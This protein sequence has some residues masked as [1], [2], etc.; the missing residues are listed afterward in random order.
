VSTRALA[1]PAA[2]TSQRGG[3]PSRPRAENVLVLYKQLAAAIDAGLTVSR[4]L[5]GAMSEMQ[6]QALRAAVEDLARRVNSG[7]SLSSAM[8]Q[9]PRC[10]SSLACNMVRSAERSGALA[11]AL[12][13]V[14]R[15][16][17]RALQVRRTIKGAMTYPAIVV[18]ASM[19]SLGVMMAVALPKFAQVFEQSGVRMPWGTRALMGAASA[20]AT[21]WWAILPAMAGAVYAFLRWARTPQGK[22]RTDTILWNLPKLGQVTRKLQVSHAASTLSGL[23]RAGVPLIE[24][25]ELVERT[26]QNSILRSG[27]RAAREATS[28]GAPLSRAMQQAQVFPGML[29]QLVAMGEETGQLPRMLE[30][31]SEMAREEAETAVQGMLRLLEP[32]MLILVG[33]MVAFIA[34]SVYVPL[35]QLGNAIAA[36]GR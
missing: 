11:S 8:A 36:S 3:K 5:Q 27:L 14:E 32:A 24:A 19:G 23:L 17:Y 33:G 6:D 1:A 25:L 28:R 29:V 34:A 13:V 21:Y 18:A 12:R 10:F 30:D 4:A 2:R 26:A 7:E 9:H 35:S 15:V 31:Y 22:R 16:E 20:A